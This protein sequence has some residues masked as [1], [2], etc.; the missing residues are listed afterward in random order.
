MRTLTNEAGCFRPCDRKGMSMRL[1]S[2]HTYDLSYLK[3]GL[4]PLWLLVRFVQR[5]IDHIVH[6][7]DHH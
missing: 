4:E 5:F 7:I 1:Y 2:F 6:G 3:K